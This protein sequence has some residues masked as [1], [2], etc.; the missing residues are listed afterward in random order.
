MLERPSYW[1]NS[2]E[3]ALHLATVLHAEGPLSVTQAAQRL[4]VGTSTAHRLLTM[5]VYR[6][7]AVQDEHRV[8]HPGPLLALSPTSSSAIASIRSIAL[9]RLVQLSRNLAMSSYLAI[10]V[11]SY[12]RFIIS[13]ESPNGMP[14][15]NRDGVVVPAHECAAGIAMVSQLS[16]SA[17]AKLYS[18]ERRGRGDTDSPELDDVEWQLQHVRERGIALVAELGT[19]PMTGIGVP[20]ATREGEIRLGLSIALPTSMYEPSIYDTTTEQLRNCAAHI[21]RDWATVEQR[22]AS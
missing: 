7:F 22:P 21:S 4:N 15:E 12:C 10:L 14:S 8:Y 3:H 9:P 11:G 13:V 20:I 5:L 2:V 19:P 16:Q 18:E 6:D 17:V 1:I